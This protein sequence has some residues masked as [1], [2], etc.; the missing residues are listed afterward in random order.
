[1]VGDGN[2]QGGT[3]DET[4]LT[5]F[6]VHAAASSGVL[7]YSSIFTLIRPSKVLIFWTVGLVEK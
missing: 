6:V 1:M 4:G 2:P 5:I 3:N 7:M